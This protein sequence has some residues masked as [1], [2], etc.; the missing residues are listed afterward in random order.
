MTVFPSE[1]SVRHMVEHHGFVLPKE[2]EYGYRGPS[3]DDSRDALYIEHAAHHHD[4]SSRPAGFKGHWHMGMAGLAGTVNDPN[5]WHRLYATAMLS[6][7]ES[8]APSERA[9]H[10]A[11]KVTPPK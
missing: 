6:N 11:K 8:G 9:Q 10:P 4:P 5:S 3:I 7:R 2:N 1:R